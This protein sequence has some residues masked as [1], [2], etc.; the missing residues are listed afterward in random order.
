MRHNALRRALPSPIFGAA[1]AVGGLF[2]V[3]WYICEQVNPTRERTYLDTYF[4]TPW[5]LDVPYEVIRLHTSDG[6]QLCG[7]WMPRPDT[8]AVVIGCHGHT[9]AKDDLLGIGGGLWRAGYNVLLF[10]MRGRGESPP[11]PNTLGGYEVNDLLA[12]VVYARERV[13]GARIGLVGFS[14]GAALALLA[15]AREPSIAAVIADCPFTS[16]ADVMA[17]HVRRYMPLGSA[18]VLAA[19]EA[20]IAQRYGYWLRDVC[21]L[22]A[23]ERLAPCA[24][25]LI[26]STEDTMVPIS[27]GHKIFAAA[28]QPKELWIHE[29]SEHCGAY[30]ADRA[31]YVERAAAFFAKHL[32]HETAQTSC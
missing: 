21:P 22:A 14:M 1:A 6:M 24:L 2:G 3:A 12:A 26:H 20:L 25:L 32:T 7:W 18:P 16:A 29:G 11:W 30:F 31:V 28:G 10:D 9:G 5:E 8:K 4:F 19:A 13:A 17:D 27:H 23:A 15:A